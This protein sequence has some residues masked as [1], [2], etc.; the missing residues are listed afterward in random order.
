[1]SGEL[2]QMVINDQ[3]GP[4]PPAQLPPRGELEQMVIGDAVASQ[5]LI[6]EEDGFSFG[7][8]LSNIPGSG[9]KYLGDIAQAVMSPI[10]TGKAIYDI[11]EGLV[12]KV[13][14]NLSEA[15]EGRDIEPLPGSEDA[16]DAFGRA[17]VDRY[18]SVDALLNTIETDPVGF[19][20]DVAGILS[21]VRRVPGLEK[22]GKVADAI[23]PV[24]GAM[25]LAAKVIP[26]QAAHKLYQSAAKFSTTLNRD[27]RQAIIQTALDNGLY[28]TSNGVLRIETM[29]DLLNGQ[30]D[31]LIDAASTAG[32]QIPVDRVFEYISDVMRNKDG[33]KVQSGKDIED[34]QKLSAAIHES[35]KG[36][37]TVSPQEMQAFKKDAYQKI[38]WNAKYQKGTPAKEEGMKAA[39]RGAK[40]SI[41]DAMPEAADINAELSKLYELQPHL[42]RAANRIENNNVI[43]LQTMLGGGGVGTA[44]ALE[45]GSAALGVSAALITAV[46]GSPKSKA[47][48][49]IALNKLGQ[50]DM[51][52][53][54][55][56]IG[57][58]EVRVALALAGRAQESGGDTV[59]PESQ[60]LIDA[61]GAN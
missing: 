28:P 1:M 33:F 51:G 44:V 58:P 5:P 18:G 34:L 42:Q 3:L 35:L 37:Q 53:I 8:M 22:V 57:T 32:T 2:E 41:V 39:A 49:A 9:A 11:G 26:E 29:T 25:Q 15:I 40:D 16:V 54:N 48:V 55:K 12:N 60:Q 27:Q 7:N 46:L 43:G 59:S 50:G 24:S 56:R 45:T 52:W 47:T 14:R 61:V 31:D 30:L 38:N 36:R 19:A 4:Q 13:G 20:A 6:M 21:P 23:E 10:D 17:I